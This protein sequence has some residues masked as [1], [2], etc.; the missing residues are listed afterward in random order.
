MRLSAATLLSAHICVYRSSS[1]HTVERDCVCETEKR[2]RSSADVQALVLLCG[3]ICVRMYVYVVS[4][5][6]CSSNLAFY[7]VSLPRVSRSTGFTLTMA[8]LVRWV[9]ISFR[10]FSR[11]SASRVSTTILTMISQSP[12]QNLFK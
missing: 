12:L 10:Y 4:K 11:I 9:H 5:I 7:R 1:L 8:V 2:S 3:S 6:N